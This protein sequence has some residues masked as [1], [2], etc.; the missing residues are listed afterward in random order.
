MLKSDPRVEDV[1]L[2]QGSLCQEKAVLEEEEEEVEDEDQE[3]IEDEEEGG[4]SG[5]DSEEEKEIEEER[6]LP[7]TN[8]QNKFSLLADDE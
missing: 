2:I 1:K 8:V 6:K 7:L 4:E 3:G 5:E